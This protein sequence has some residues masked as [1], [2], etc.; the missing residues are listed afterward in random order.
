MEGVDYSG[1]HPSVSGLVAAGKKF[2][3]RY[4]GTGGSWKLITRAEADALRAAG[5]AIVA[6]VEGE[7]N[8]LLGGF[9]TGVYWARTADEHF[10][11]LG[12][13]KDRPIYLSVDFDASSPHWTAIDAALRGAASV[14]GAD[15]VGV[16][17]GYDTIAH[18]ASAGSAK[19]FWQTY[20][21]SGG[22]WH[23]K[24]HIEQ[25]RNGVSLAGGTVD[26]NRS[27]TL[28][29]GQWGSGMGTYED[30][31]RTERMR[32]PYGDAATNPRIWAETAMF[33]IG[34][35]TALAVTKLNELL[36]LL[37]AVAGRVDL[38]PAELEAVRQAAR[39]G[40]VS[41]SDALVAAVLAKLPPDTLTVED[42]AAAVRAASR[43]AWSA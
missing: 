41:A 12:M 15:R 38:D 36:T 14:I 30:V 10:R 40:A 32:N 39:E 27:K 23:P 28:D 35:H 16:Y 13:P 29:F 26:L 37:K 31:W 19:W 18:C 20:A 34:S 6:N 3:V 8:G 11:T 43:E 25:Y 1:D 9:T 5:I 2:V 33:N 4:G 22:R 42:V 17:G 21:W 7:A 24:N